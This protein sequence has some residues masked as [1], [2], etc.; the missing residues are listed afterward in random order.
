MKELFLTAYEAN[1]WQKVQLIFSLGGDVNWKD[2]RGMFGLHI[3]ARGNYRELLELLLVQ[4]GVDVNI[5]TNGNLTP[6]MWACIKGH[7]NIMRRLCQVTGIR[8]NSRGY[9]AGGTALYWAVDQ[10]NLACVSVLMAGILSP[11]Q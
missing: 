4:T 7:E 5:R 11:G 9:V 8:L 6:L 10:N 3:A 2:Q 1:D